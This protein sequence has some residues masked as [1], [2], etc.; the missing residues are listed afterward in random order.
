MK[1]IDFCDWINSFPP[2]E[3]KMWQAFCPKAHQAE[4]E[5]AVNEFRKL[6]GRSLLSQSAAEPENERCTQ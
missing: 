6:M 2:E 4:I 1:E 3:R 5:V